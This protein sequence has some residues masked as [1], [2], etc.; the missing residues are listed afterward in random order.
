MKE[1]FTYKEAFITIDKTALH[2][3]SMFNNSKQSSN[4]SAQKIKPK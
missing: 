3:P 4:D 2:L 1:Y